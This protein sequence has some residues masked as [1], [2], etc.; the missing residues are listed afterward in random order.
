VI[1]LTCYS[2]FNYAKEALSLGAVDY[3]VKVLM[4][5]EDFEKALQKARETN[6]REE[7][8]K[9]TNKE[10]Q[11][12]RISRI[13]GDIISSPNCTQ[14]SL[15]GIMESH[16]F[17]ITYPTRFVYM[18]MISSPN[19]LVFIDQ[20]ISAYLKEND[21]DFEWL[22]IDKGVY[23]LIFNDFSQSEKVFLDCLE[24]LIQS[25][26]ARLDSELHF[27][28]GRVRLYCIVSTILTEEI[29]FVDAFRK[30][31]TWNDLSFYQCDKVIFYDG[32]IEVQ[33]L[34]PDLVRD[35]KKQLKNVKETKEDMSE[36]IMDK[37]YKWALDN[38]IQP[39]EL[40]NLVFDMFKD[41]ESKDNQKKVNFLKILQTNSIDELVETLVQ[42]LGL[43]MHQKGPILIE[44]REVIKIINENIESPITLSYI[45]SK[46]ALSPFY[47]G[48]IFAEEVGESF[49]DYVTG[50]RM[51]KAVE[52][53]QSTN[54]KVYEVAEKV[55]IPNYRYFSNLFR[56]WTG[57]T[58][59]EYKRG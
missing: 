17:K 10:K 8:Y 21:P 3:I 33:S 14:L 5:D 52:L 26:N 2:E 59:K 41:I 47:L 50:I 12:I 53:L 31:E 19:N 9:S 20:E 43:N 18:H 56:N 46:V 51:K 27:M 35:I 40:K 32:G 37:F 34:N 49:N 44:I 30:I 28:N 11:R 6:E 23:G 29:E 15:N 57:Q 36:F 48:K 39:S 7:L 38:T 55:G 13:L 45:S 42:E 22:N 25:L 16:G 54:L 24:A 4:K 1:V 58:P